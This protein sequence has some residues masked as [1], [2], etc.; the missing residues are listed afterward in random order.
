MEFTGKITK[1]TPEVTVGQKELPKITFVIEDVGE[2]EDYKRNS[3][4]VDVLGDKTELIKQFNEWDVVRVGLNFKSNE[5]NDRIYNRIT[6]RRIDAADAD[7]S[8]DKG[9]AAPAAAKN[10]EDLPF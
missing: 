4:A 8:S 10:D 1:I 2:M 7:G 3:I 5:Y 9:S 6:A